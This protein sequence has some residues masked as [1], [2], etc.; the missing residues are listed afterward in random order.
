MSSYP[1]VDDYLNKVDYQFPNYVP[2]KAAIKF[3][4]FIKLVNQ[5]KGGEENKSPVVHMKMLDA[6]FNK[7]KRTA[8]MCHRGIAKTT[9][10]AEYMFFYLAIL[11]SNRIFN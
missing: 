5:D 1:K 2:S 9:L 3:I 4:T 8:I 11:E 6:V 10:M 7:K